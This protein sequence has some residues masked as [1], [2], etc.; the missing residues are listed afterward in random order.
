MTLVCDTSVLYPAL[1]RR[2]RD[3]AV[4]AEL[5]GG[6]IALVVPAPTLVEIDQLAQSRGVPHATT[7]LLDS[8]SDGTFVLVSPDLE[9]YTRI[10]DLVER[11]ANLPLGLVDASVVAIAERLEETTVATLDRRHFAVVKPLHCKAFTLVP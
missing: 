1:D 10:R 2:D 5:L 6:P 8:L 9:D 7:A 3:H 4:C 11:Y